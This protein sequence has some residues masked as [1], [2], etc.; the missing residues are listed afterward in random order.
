[1]TAATSE[2]TGL[3]E[4]MTSNSACADATVAGKNDGGEKEQF[5]GVSSGTVL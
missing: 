4:A 2:W 3:I 1:M 5:G